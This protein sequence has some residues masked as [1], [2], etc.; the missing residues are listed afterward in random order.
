MK[1]TPEPANKANSTQRPPPSLTGPDE[2][3]APRRTT[4]VRGERGPE[5]A[6]RFD[7][8]GKQ[9]LSSHRAG[10]GQPQKLPREYAH[11]AL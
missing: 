2:Y 7:P 4:R 8:F 6:Y 9:D 10:K 5:L 3:T 11:Q 1:S